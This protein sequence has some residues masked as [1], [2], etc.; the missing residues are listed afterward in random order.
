MPT[1]PGAVSDSAI[2]ETGTTTRS[3]GPLIRGAIASAI[4]VVVFLA[5]T[6]GS[7]LAPLVGLV[8][9]R[10]DVSLMT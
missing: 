8:A 3:T 5:A 4:M 10:S 7:A 1:E 9:G 6:G 2:I